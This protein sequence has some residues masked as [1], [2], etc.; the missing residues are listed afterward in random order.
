MGEVAE[1][2]GGAAEVFESPVDGL[3]GAVAGAGAVEKCEDVARPLLIAA[4][5]SCIIAFAFFLSGSR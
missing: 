1:A 5:T 4:I 3:G 2:E